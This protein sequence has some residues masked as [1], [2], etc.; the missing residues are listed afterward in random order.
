MT[1]EKQRLWT[2]EVFDD[3]VLDI[4]CD[5]QRGRGEEEETEKKLLVN[6]VRIKKKKKGYG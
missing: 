5:G 4:F 1:S 2:E 6:K 3:G